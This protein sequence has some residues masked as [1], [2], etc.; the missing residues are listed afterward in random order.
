M[1]L[2]RDLILIKAPSYAVIQL[3]LIKDCG[4]YHRTSLLDK[5]VKIGTYIWSSR[6][7][8]FLTRA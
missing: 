1:H 2:H 5:N 3:I 4:K 8:F 7:L 6:S